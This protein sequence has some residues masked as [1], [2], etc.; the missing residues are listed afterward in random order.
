M[1][2]DVITPERTVLS[3]EVDEILVPTPSG[4]IG[5][6]P[7]H[8]NLVSQISQG[9]IIIKKKGKEQYFAITGG[10]LEVANGKISV[11]A[12][13]AAHAED[14]DV[15]K[16]LKAQKRAE[17]ILKKDRNAISDRDFAVA[18]AELQKSLLQLNIA[19]R[20]KPRRNI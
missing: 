8:I 7:H 3:D 12:D 19:R 9:E 18:S 14:I 10:F 6:L 11:I 20:R 15:E 1:H 2:L 16:A 13:Y 5:I 4:Q 17:E